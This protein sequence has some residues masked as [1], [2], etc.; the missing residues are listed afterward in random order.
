[1]VTIYTVPGCPKCNQLKKQASELGIEYKESHNV[2]EVIS[3]GFHSAPVLRIDDKF[4]DRN[5]AK[6]ALE[7]LAV[8]A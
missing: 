6:K 2:D 3:A 8:G 4:Y 5:N 1:M 7:L